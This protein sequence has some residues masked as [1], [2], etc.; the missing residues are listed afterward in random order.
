MCHRGTRTAV[1]TSARREGSNDLP[2]PTV[3][4]RSFPGQGEA[5]PFSPTRL[6]PIGSFSEEYRSRKQ[7]LKEMERRD[8]VR[9]G[10]RAPESLSHCRNFAP[11]L[12]RKAQFRDYC[13]PNPASG[14]A[15]NTPVLKGV[16]RNFNASKCAV[17][18]ALFYQVEGHQTLHRPPRKV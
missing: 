11:P 4:A 7:R 12:Q 5:E 13:I 16:E 2:P 3:P 14:Q 18:S 6:E 1:P 15:G 17:Q 9:A 8:Q 10:G